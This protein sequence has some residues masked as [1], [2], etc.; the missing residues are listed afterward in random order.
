M[1]RLWF[2]L[3]L[4]VSMLIPGEMALAAGTGA[5]NVNGAAYSGAQ[6]GKAGTMPGG[7]G[8]SSPASSPGKAGTTPN[9]KGPSGPPGHG[10]GGGVRG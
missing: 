7:K 3:C 1:P 10:S 5:G 6:P 4:M 9:G 8:P 2:A